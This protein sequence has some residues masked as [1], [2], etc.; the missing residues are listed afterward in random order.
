MHTLQTYCNSTY[1]LQKIKTQYPTAFELY[2]ALQLDLK[3]PTDPTNELQIILD[4]VPSE[5]Q[6]L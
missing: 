2:M 6:N 4:I 1:F 3:T 5:Y